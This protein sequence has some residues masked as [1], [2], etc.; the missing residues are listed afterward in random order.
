MQRHLFW[1]FIFATVLVMT[2]TAFVPL[3]F[4]AAP[5]S[6]IQHPEIQREVP[7]NGDT[8]ELR[9]Q[10]RRIAHD[11]VTMSLDKAEKGA[12]DTA[13]AAM[14]HNDTTMSYVSWLTTILFGFLT[15]F[16]GL[17]IGTVIYG[18]YGLVKD[19]RA[20]LEKA[21]R[22]ATASNAAIQN[23]EQ[24]IKSASER[25]KISY[26]QAVAFDNAAA[27]ALTEISKYLES[28]PDIESS[29]ILGG[30]AEFPTPDEVM[31]M[32]EVDVVLVL[33]E[34][35]TPPQ[36]EKF[37]RAFLS[38]GKY[39]RQV[40][41]YPRAIARYNRATQ[42]NPKSWEAFEGL[43]RLYVELAAQR[44]R[45]LEAKERLLGISEKWCKQADK[46]GG[47][48][49]KTLCDLAA[50]ADLRQDFPKAINLYKQAQNLDPK[51]EWLGA[52]Y[53]P[54]CIFAQ[55]LG[56]FQNALLEIKKIISRDKIREFVKNDADF[57]A[58]RK[59]PNFGPQLVILMQEP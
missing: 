40:G 39:W 44:G 22:E 19:A 10:M 43:A 55:E 48:Q 17:G 36:P 33:G 50:V 34:K 16:A 46:A 25:V 20:N 14:K 35:I 11:E 54:A 37:A 59:D 53:N 30:P 57:D 51:G 3:T 45:T 5:T 8:A 18:E 15:I 49:A 47:Q 13:T 42:L 41:N 38:L 24:N 6:K 58:L 32:E 9:E 31:E 52:I 23:L 12:I 26:D 56:D 21:K 28:L 29:A 4:G 2:I 1:Q 27:N 7:H